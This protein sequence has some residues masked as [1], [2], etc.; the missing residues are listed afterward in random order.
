VYKLI[1]FANILSKKIEIRKE[2][3]RIIE[4]LRNTNVT[5][6]GTSLFASKV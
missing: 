4:R 2:N 6:S 1:E 5:K 3:D